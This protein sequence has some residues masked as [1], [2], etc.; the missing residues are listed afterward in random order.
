MPAAFLDCHGSTVK[1]AEMVDLKVFSE[2]DYLRVAISLD[3]PAKTKVEANAEENLVFIRFDST[4]VGSLTKQSFLYP[5]NPHLE[6]IALLPL[7]QGSTVARI[8]ARHPFKVKTYEINKPP[9]FVLELN[10][11][12]QEVSSNPKVDPPRSLDHYRRGLQQM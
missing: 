9:R 8:K 3:Q 2:D 11:T 10:D 5:E 1:A 6:S 4:G 12:G 7:G